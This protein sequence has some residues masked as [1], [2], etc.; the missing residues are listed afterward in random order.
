MLSRH[1]MGALANAMSLANNN[2]CC[3]SSMLRALIEIWSPNYEEV[4]PSYKELT[5]DLL[6]CCLFLFKAF[7][8]IIQKENSN[9]VTYADW[10]DLWYNRN[11]PYANPLKS[12]RYIDMSEL[13]YDG[14]GNVILV[15]KLD[16]P[17]KWTFRHERKLRG[18]P[19]QW[20]RLGIFV[21]LDGEEFV[22]VETFKAAAQM[23][24]GVT[25][26]LVP[27]ILACIYRGLRPLTKVLEGLSQPDIKLLYL[28][29]D[30]SWGF[31]CIT[32]L[33]TRAHPGPRVDDG[34]RRADTLDFIVSIKAGYVVLH[35]ESR[36]TKK[37]YNPHQFARQNGFQQRLSGRHVELPQGGEVSDLYRFWL[38]LTRVHNNTFLHTPLAEGGVGSRVDPT[39]VKWWN[40]EVF[41]S[42]FAVSIQFLKASEARNFMA[43]LM[44]STV[45]KPQGKS[46]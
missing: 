32:T 20:D 25:Y 19:K 6:P 33:G 31:E 41:P 44:K 22:R 1:K 24:I 15:P 5:E 37:S 40:E 11:P 26:S 38:S 7:A 17:L 43:S 8:T 13:K 27:P 35:Q 9:R 2:Y 14:N 36:F 10:L 3:P 46:K 12:K 28:W 42:I 29:F 21:F 34:Q 45:I 39:Y 16:C 4:V 30:N 18:V 23:A